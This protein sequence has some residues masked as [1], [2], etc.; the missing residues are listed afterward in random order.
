GEDDDDAL[1][2]AVGHE[3]AH[4]DLGHAIRCLQDPGVQKMTEGTLQKLYW[5]IIPFGYLATDK[6]DQEFDADEWVLYRMEGFPRSRHEM[7]T[8]LNKL[9]GYAK[10][11]GF[12][13][14]RGKPQ[15]GHD[16]SPL[17]N[18]YRAKTAAW[19]RLKHLKKLMDERAKA[20]K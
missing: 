16:L 20:P 19:A 6:V 8:F 2:F 15:P 11:H 7:L 17:E 1:Q 14:G 9:D 5:L 3:I 4:V 12:G 18:H 10:N 13:N